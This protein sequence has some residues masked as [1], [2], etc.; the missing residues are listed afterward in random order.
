MANKK[1]LKIL[2]AASEAAPL[3]SAGGLGDVIGSLPLALR[4]LGC[5]VVIVLPAYRQALD[6]AKDFRI[7]ARNLP[8]RMDH[9]Y[10]KADILVGQIAPGVPTCLVR[11]DKLFD[12]DS[13]Y[14]NKHGEYPDNPERFIFFSR[15]IPA[16]C[17]ASGFAPDVI[18]ANDWQTGLIM[19]ILAEGALPGTAGVFAI[20]NMG[21]LGLVPLEKKPFIGLPDKYYRMEGMEYYGKISLL[22]AGIV[23]AQAVATVSP[24]YAQEIRTPEFG[25]GLDGLMLSV[26]DRLFGILNGVDYQ[27]WNSATDRHLAANYSS[28]DLCGK[29]KCKRD[30]LQIMCLPDKMFKRPLVGMVTRLVK[31]KGCDIVAEAA[32]KLFALDLSLI[33]LGTGDR[34]YQRL[35]SKLQARYPNQFALRLDFDPVLAHKIMAGS[36]MFLMPSLYEPCGLTQMYSLKYGTLPIVRAVG[37]LKDTVIDP[38]EGQGNGTGFKFEL[39]HEKD[40]VR[41]VQRATTVFKDK[42]QWKSMMRNGMAQDFSWRRSAKEYLA[43]FEHAM[44]ARRDKTR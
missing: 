30:L 43:V 33:L 31:Q 25:S 29:Y 5:H 26:K 20:H 23:Y 18:L 13:L 37:G 34:I 42:K 36:D 16:F 22:K 24:T 40:L 1:S 2:V 3:A 44:Q 39:Y 32:Q 19:P 8:V 38:L 21:Y 7:T 6:K 14:G 12:R 28:Q 4:D 15:S 11:C 41:A 27:V 35:F 10:L 17:S 9:N